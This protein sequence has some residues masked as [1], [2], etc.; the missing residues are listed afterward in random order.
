[1]PATV[2]RSSGMKS[3]NSVRSPSVLMLVSSPRFWSG[4][5]WW[6]TSRLVVLPDMPG[7]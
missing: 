2:P 1:M 6:T 7:P 4:A 5:R 3:K